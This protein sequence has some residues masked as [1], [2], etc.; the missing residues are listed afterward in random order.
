MKLSDIKIYLASKSPRRAE[1]L[2]QIGVQYELMLMRDSQ[3]RTVDVPEIVMPGEL[4]HDY[5][6]RITAQ[7]AQT[8]WNILVQ[9]NLPLHPVLTADTTVVLNGTVYGKPAN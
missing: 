5:V 6:A 1:L 2:Q 8:A 3:G 4:P 9:R 7:K